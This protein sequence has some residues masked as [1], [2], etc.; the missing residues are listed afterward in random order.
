MKKLTH[1]TENHDLVLNS[2][3]SADQQPRL[4]EKDLYVLAFIK[5]K[6]AE[7][8]SKLQTCVEKL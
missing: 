8:V 5:V 3:H 7:Y 6:L 1:L 2:Y 4:A